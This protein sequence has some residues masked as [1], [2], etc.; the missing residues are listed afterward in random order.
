M[1]GVL[2]AI[3][4]ALSLL[5]IATPADAQSD[6]TKISATVE[7]AWYGRIEGVERPQRYLEVLA[8][9][10]ARD[11]YRATVLFGWADGPISPTPARIS[12]DGPSV[13]V[14]FTARTGAALKVRFDGSAAASGTYR[15]K[16]ADHPIRYSRLAQRSEYGWLAGVWNAPRNGETRVLDIKRVVGTDDGALIAIG[17]FGIAE[18]P[19]SVRQLV[20]RITGEPDA[21]RLRWRTGS[22][23]GDVK[24]SGPEE[25][26]GT[27][28]AAARQGTA[29]SRDPIVF[30]QSGAAAARAG[31]TASIEVGKPFPELRLVAMNGQMVPI[32]SFRGKTVLVTFFQS[33]DVWS[34]SELKSFRVAKARYGDK[35]AI[36][37]VNQQPGAA[38]APSKQTTTAVPTVTAQVPVAVKHVPESWLVDANG[39]VVERVNYIPEHALIGLLDRTVQ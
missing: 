32:A 18:D 27:F 14:S 13:V 25:L 35:L 1:R 5:A 2:S 39:I 21:A 24:R 11:G 8:V 29:A 15:V 31:G 28:G 3:A 10:P 37:T 17:Q 38:R 16:Q 9:E 30:R 34:L 12:L 4:V 36:L 23:S 20:A 6:A 7:G 19:T 26:S 22:T 33:W